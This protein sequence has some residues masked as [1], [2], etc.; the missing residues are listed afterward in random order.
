VHRSGQ[1]ALTVFG[2]DVMP[3]KCCDRLRNAAAA[4]VA[5]EV[6]GLPVSEYDMIAGLDW[7]F[8]HRA[9]RG[10]RTGLITHSRPPR[11]VTI[12][13]RALV[14]NEYSVHRLSTDYPRPDSRAVSQQGFDPNRVDVSAWKPRLWRA[15]T[16][17]GSRPG[18]LARKTDVSNARVL[19]LVPNGA[20]YV[21]RTTPVPDWR[22][23]VK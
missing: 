15:V 9:D 18:N 1:T 22:R 2:S 17:C 7:L 13:P 21:E 11:A 19:V 23:R 5:L 16:S 4:E 20:L 3:Q 10:D 8:A 6:D 14:V 12:A